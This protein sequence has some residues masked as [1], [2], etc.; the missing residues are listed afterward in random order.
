[1]RSFTVIVL[2]LIAGAIQAQSK[3]AFGK[4][5]TIGYTSNF[6]H[7]GDPLNIKENEHALAYQRLITRKKSLIL[8]YATVSY[9]SKFNY[10]GSPTF[11]LSTIDSNGKQVDRTLTLINPATFKVKTYSF[12]LR[13]FVKSKGSIA[14]YGSFLEFKLGLS[15]INKPKSDWSG[16]YRDQ[17]GNII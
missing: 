2:L 13:T 17:K 15:L 10:E 4:R 14:P 16:A 9:Q 7:F 6:L 1:M 3:Y 12:G 8:E 11:K 5:N